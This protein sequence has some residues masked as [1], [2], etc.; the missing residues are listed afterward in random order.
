MIPY[1]LGCDAAEPTNGQPAQAGNQHD[2]SHSPAG[3]RYRC[4][5]LSGSMSAIL[6]VDLPRSRAESTVCV[7]VEHDWLR[8]VDPHHPPRSVND[9]ARLGFNEANCNALGPGRQSSTTLGNIPPRRSRHVTKSVM[10]TSLK[11]VGFEQYNAVTTRVVDCP[12]VS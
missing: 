4:G 3:P 7:A 6:R 2:A 9:Q 8:V 12:D 1:D 10:I 11:F 5:R